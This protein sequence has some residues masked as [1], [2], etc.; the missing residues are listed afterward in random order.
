MKLQHV[1][2][3]GT[4]GA[5]LKHFESDLFITEGLCA[6]DTTYE[7]RE[8]SKASLRAQARSIPEILSTLFHK[9]YLG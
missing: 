6:F 4:T 5:Y 7:Y 9:S 3:K 1:R 8:T 2:W